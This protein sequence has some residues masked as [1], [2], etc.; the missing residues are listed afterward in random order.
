MRAHLQNLAAASGAVYVNASD[1]VRDDQKFED[2]M[3]LNEAGAK[4]FSVQL[5]KSIL[6]LDAPAEQVADRM[7]WTGLH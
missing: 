7:A 2:A 3:H 6:L 1:W 4:F 5:A